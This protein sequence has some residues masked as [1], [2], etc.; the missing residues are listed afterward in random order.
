MGG[1]A[2]LTLEPARDA[3]LADARNRAR[4]L[5]DQASAEATARIEQARRAGAEIVDRARAQGEAEGRISG[6]RE[7]A[8]ESALA[9]ME[10]LAAQRAAYEELRRRARAAVLALRDDP[11]YPELLERLAAACR[12]DLG[13]RAQ[14][15]TDPPDAGGV[16]ATAGTRS[17]DYTLIALAE[18][19]IDAL[20]PR[21][22]R[23]WE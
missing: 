4:Q 17:V 6:A 10:V 23:L 11:G 22:R 13:E 7:E 5:I 9:R 8:R 16:R 19:C 1:G 15:E 3:L 12:N 18:R 2:G 20:G 14:L 21:L